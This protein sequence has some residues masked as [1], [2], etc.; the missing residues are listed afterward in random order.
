MNNSNVLLQVLISSPDI[1]ETINL[2]GEE[3]IFG[4]SSGSTVYLNDPAFSRSHFKLIVVNGALQLTDLGSSNGTFINGVQVSPVNPESVIKGD[5]ITVNNSPIKIKIQKIDW[6]VPDDATVLN[7]S[8]S[9]LTQVA[10]DPL[11]IDNLSA[12]IIKEANLR[13]EQIIAGAHVESKKILSDAQAASDKLI[14]DK[15]ARAD[16]Y[17]EKLVADKKA[18]I[19]LDLEEQ[20]EKSRNEMLD[21][22]EMERIDL[23]SDLENH[24]ADILKEHDQKKMELARE[25][26]SDVEKIK[27]KEAEL[28]DIE[29]TFEKE[30]AAKNVELEQKIAEQKKA[31]ALLTASHEEEKNKQLQLMEAQFENKKFQLKEELDAIEAKVAAAQKEFTSLYDNYNNQKN[32]QVKTLEDLLAR[33]EQTQVEI[34]KLE[35]DLEKSKSEADKYAKDSASLKSSLQEDIKKI[36]KQKLD[37]DNNY[38]NENSK[39]VSVQKKV[40]DTETELKT[41]EADLAVKKKLVASSVTENK[42][43]EAEKDDIMSKLAPLKMELNE[44]IRKNEAASRQ[45]ADL[46]ASHNKDVAGLKSNFLQKKKDLEEEM[47]KLKLAEE[48]RLQNLTRQEL[49]QINKI[50]ED[51]LRI[52]LD[53]ED[54]I[55]KELSNAT[56]KVFATTIGMTKFREIAPDFEKSIRTSL[57]AGVLKLLQ[58]ELS[59]ADPLKK[60]NL[61]STQKTWKPMAIGVAISAVVFGAIPMTYQY[62]KDQNDPVRLQIEAEARMAAAAKPIKKFE[63][64]KVGKLGVDLTD[65]VIYTY[66]YYETVSQEK[67]RSG[68][69]KEGSVY[70]YK[71]WKIDEEKSIQAY[72]MILSLIDVLREKSLKIDPDYEKRDIDKM[73]ALEK[74]TMKKLEKILGNEVRIEA[75]LKFQNR[76]YETYSAS[77][78]NV[79]NTTDTTQP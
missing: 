55:T 69:M 42:K 41:I 59:P 22:I 33:K 52:V 67:F 44:M 74:E 58:N 9:K 73:M 78:A 15:Q 10:L 8:V 28:A 62:V 30:L 7:I 6:P 68:L 18:A 76:Y 2:D 34:K 13:V 12:E 35:S 17:I 50:K 21:K 46:L 19:K 56:S 38:K 47:V 72:S 75:A 16:A 24:K 31:L 77:P 53:L 51:S 43:L 37:I 3:F 64:E 54:S 66:N 29:A 1:N 36:E 23:K 71:Q 48:E 49:N 45:N 57:Q 40:S 39:L 27:A 61:T 60:K 70:M 20:K 65:S 11:N 63:P 79:P 26:E 5:E 14:A 4:R 25:L 32:V